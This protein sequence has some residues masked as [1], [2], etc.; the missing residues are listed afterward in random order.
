MVRGAFRSSLG[1]AMKYKIRWFSVTASVV[2]LSIAGAV[3][4]DNV[5]NDVVTGGAG[6]NDTVTVGGSTTIAYYI[7]AMG[8]SC[9]AADGSAAL[10]TI[11]TPAAVTA[12]PG[13]LVFSQCELANA[14]SVVFS[15]ATIGDYSI[16]VSVSDSSG[17]Y[18]TTTANFTLHVLAASDTTPPLVTC[19][20]PNAS[21]WYGSDV[22]VPCTAG[23]AGGL[24]N[25][26]DAAFSL[27]TSVSVGAETPVASTD[28]RNVCDTSANC[29]PAGPY[30]FKVDKASPALAPGVSP[31]PVELNGSAVASANASDGGSGIASQGCD[32]VIT[33]SLGP[34]TV[35]C[36]A[37][38]NVGNRSSATADYTV[39]EKAAAGIP[40]LSEWGL[41]A[42][43][44]I[45]AGAGMWSVGA[46]KVDS[47]G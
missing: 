47:R 20:V 40:A 9:D 39:I 23:D 29:T 31:N 36:T 13:S 37:T 28:S 10:V 38:D 25:P 35:N 16:T 26:A 24:A 42:L 22:T 11:N 7:Q 14:K 4:A 5:R 30:T 8:G 18:N 41:F 33:S 21:V 1:G 44:S 43:I 27:S 2:L 12:T 46:A 17:S 19:T 3:L 15:A 45:L 32:S 34:G 6:Q